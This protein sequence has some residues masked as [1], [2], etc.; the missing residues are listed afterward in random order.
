MRNTNRNRSNY[1]GA[2]FRIII[3]VLTVILL[4][5][6]PIAAAN[7]ADYT[8][9]TDGKTVSAVLTLDNQNIFY[10]Q[11]PGIFGD[12]AVDDITDLKLIRDDGTDVSPINSNGTYTF[13]KGNYLLTYT[14]AVD[15]NTIYGKYP[16]KF[17]VSVTLPEPYTTGHLIL[18]TVQNNGI[19][20]K[21]GTN[22]VI[23]YAQTNSAQ[24]TYYDKNREWMLYTFLGIWAVFCII[25]LSRYLRLRKKQK[26]IE[27]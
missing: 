9:S 13:E 1:R 5:A 18:G 11:N 4:L 20:T 8:V 3:S 16:A 15:A 22:T 10:I 25:F 27:D 24:L 12:T 21:E 14:A 6:T 19:I 7:T 2:A 23:T 26:I 17:D